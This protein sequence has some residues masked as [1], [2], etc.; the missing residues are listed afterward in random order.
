[1]N[2]YV[3]AGHFGSTLSYAT[4]TKEICK[5]LSRRGLLAATIN[6]DDKYV[7]FDAV[8]MTEDALNT[9]RLLAVTLPSHHIEQLAEFFGAQRSVRCNYCPS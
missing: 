5:A 7:E 4:I 8:R 3:V 6:F 9:E 1:M 2:R